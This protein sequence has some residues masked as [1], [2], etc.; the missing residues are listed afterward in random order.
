MHFHISKKNYLTCLKLCKTDKCF[1]GILLIMFFSLLQVSCG[2]TQKSKAV[3]AAEDRQAQTLLKFNKANQ[4]LDDNQAEDAAK[5]YDQILV[6]NPVTSLDLLVLYNSG[7]AYFQSQHCDQAV[8]RFRKVIRSSQKSP[9]IQ[10]R[11]KLYLSDSYTCIGDDKKSI[12]NLIEIFQGHFQLP[13]EVVRTEIPAKLA[14]AYARMGNGKE[15]EKYFRAAEKGLSAVNRDAAKSVERIKTLARTLYLMGNIN[16]LNTQTMTYENYFV[17]LR[18][19]QK[20]LYKSVEYNEPEWSPKSY[21]QID[22][23]YNQTWSYLDKVD[24]GLKLKI[25]S[26]I[27]D[28]EV[29]KRDAEVNKLKIIQM[30][31]R[32]LDYLFKE[33][34]PTEEDTPA[35]AQLIKKMY[36]AKSKLQNYLNT[37]IVGSGLTQE[38]LKAESLKRSGRA[39]NPD[40]ILEETY[41]K[42]NKIK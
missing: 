22:Q 10:S 31:I 34:I 25:K 19:L 41:L 18:A 26:H 1:V 30:A 11:A 4:L 8:D 20:Y 36:S 40:P 13:A 35:V 21:T 14:A 15:A 12:S 33:H 29:L 23:A 3:R 32:T 17:S 16:Q 27:G 2:M 6:S 38:A 9:A 24:E 39:L 42:N 37:N 5:M 7:V 28:I